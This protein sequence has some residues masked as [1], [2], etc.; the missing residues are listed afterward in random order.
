MFYLDASV[1]VAAI[2]WEDRSEGVWQWLEAHA[3]LPILC[4]GW[5]AT[6]VSGALSIKVRTGAYTL[7]NR[8]AAWNDWRRFR[9][10]SLAEIDIAPAHFET[11]AAFCARAD[12]GLRAGDSLHLAIAQSG[13]LTLLTL[14]R[15][16]AD[17][18]L[19]L[20]IPVESL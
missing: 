8:L 6:E 10:P 17:A 2:A 19:Q 14:D 13:G 15:T 5:T 11:A 3:D 4:S 16:M 7:E 20:G 9:Q 1:A 12:L 18:A